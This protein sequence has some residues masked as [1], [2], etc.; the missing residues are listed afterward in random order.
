MNDET[1]LLTFPCKFSVKVMGKNKA[2]FVSKVLALIACYA[3][4]I[5]PNDYKIRPSKN[6]KYLAITVTILATNKKQLDA[7]YQNLTNC[8]EVLMAL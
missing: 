2:D 1:T 8:P 6:N 3:G 4:I 5:A 7:I